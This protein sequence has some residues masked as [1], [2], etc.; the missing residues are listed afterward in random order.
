MAPSL[1]P[2]VCRWK[3]CIVCQRAFWRL[4]CA[5]HR[6]MVSAAISSVLGS[7]KVRALM[8]V[9]LH[10]GFGRKMYTDYE[11]V[12]K[13]RVLSSYAI[14]FPSYRHTASLPSQ[15]FAL[16]LILLYRP[17]YPPSNFATLSF[18]GAILTSKP[19]ATSSSAN[20]PVSTFLLFLAK[21][22]RTDSLTR[23]SRREEKDWKGS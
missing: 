18:D 16:T 8:L 13:V 15:L 10:A 12:C 3:T 20:P 2:C 23:S 21:C 11:I 7:D 6:R 4:R 1:F 5:T 14:P 17:T 9:S 22:S 19:S